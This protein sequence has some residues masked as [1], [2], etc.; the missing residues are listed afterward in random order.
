MG[1][2]LTQEL[3]LV[4]AAA[5]TRA[6]LASVSDT[7]VKPTGRELFGEIEYCEQNAPR[8]HQEPEGDHHHTGHR[9]KDEQVGYSKANDGDSDPE[10]AEIDRQASCPRCCLRTLPP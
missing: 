8:Q 7:L 2:P 9:A 10:E 3:G 6:R 5:V 4:V 1:N